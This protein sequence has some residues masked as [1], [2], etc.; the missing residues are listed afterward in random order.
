MR[1]SVIDPQVLATI[2]PLRSPSY[3]NHTSVPNAM[4]VPVSHEAGSA[5]EPAVA[6]MV[7]NGIDCPTEIG[8]ALAHVS[9]GGSG[10][11]HETAAVRA[12]SVSHDWLQQNGSMVQV[13]V[14]QVLSLQPTPACASKQG[15]VELEHTGWQPACCA[16]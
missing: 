3:V 6:R 7:E 11:P 1:M 2:A 9:F 16:S 8:R 12:Q 10:A 15:P 13:A 4:P 5:G 14:Q